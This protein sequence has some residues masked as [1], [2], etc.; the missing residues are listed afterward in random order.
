VPENV[1]GPGGAEGWSG[2]MKASVAL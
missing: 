1:S 2:L